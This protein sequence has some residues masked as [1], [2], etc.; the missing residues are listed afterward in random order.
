MKAHSSIPGVSRKPLL[1]IDQPDAG[2][3]FIETIV[4]IAIVVLLTSTVAFTASRYI[5][6]ARRARVRI[7]LEGISL[8]LHAYYLDNNTYPTEGQGLAALWQRPVLHPSPD[9]WSGPYLDGPPPDD[10]WGS[11]YEYSRPGPNGLPF[12]VRSFGADGLRGGSREAADVSTA[13]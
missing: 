4:V 8:A 10:P 13:E 2:W 9:T 6:Q 5:E 11:P 7:Q 1:D 12:E 3:T